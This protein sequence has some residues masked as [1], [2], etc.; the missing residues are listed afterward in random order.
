M[1]NSI[2]KN[3]EFSTQEEFEQ[4]RK[5]LID[6]KRKIETYIVFWI[7]IGII[8]TVI[9]LSFPPTP[10]LAILAFA[11]PIFSC[12]NQII[13]YGNAIEKIEANANTKETEPL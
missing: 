12:I 2:L 8:G 9:I 10:P 3:L 5:I 1:D 4:K 13:E 7:I 11:I 6:N